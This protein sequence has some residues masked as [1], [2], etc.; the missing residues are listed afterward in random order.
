MLSMLFVVCRKDEKGPRLLSLSLALLL[1]PL[2]LF[3]VPLLDEEKERELERL[4]R[5]RRIFLRFC[6]CGAARRNAIEALEDLATGREGPCGPLAGA[7]GNEV[8]ND[9]ERSS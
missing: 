8:L 7:P 3:P 2:S 5:P 4:R 1:D 9:S 6:L